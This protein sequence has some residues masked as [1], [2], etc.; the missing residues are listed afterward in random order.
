MRRPKPARVEH[1]S[2]AHKYETRL[3]ILES[4]LI[5]ILVPKKKSSVTISIDR[6]SRHR[7]QRQLAEVKIVIL[8]GTTIFFS[9]SVCVW[10]TFNFEEE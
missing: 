4:A 1:T 3:E 9:M 8:L 7:C 6:C 10:G 2:N 5:F